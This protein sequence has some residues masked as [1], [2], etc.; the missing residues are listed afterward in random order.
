MAE[1]YAAR[2]LASRRQVAIKLLDP[3]LVGDPGLI[4]RFRHEFLILTRVA[5]PHL[6]RAVDMAMTADAQPYFTMELIRGESLEERLRRVGRIGARAAIE[7]GLQ[8]CGA[9]AA[10][11]R[12]GVIH[13]DVKPSNILLAPC[14]AGLDSRLIDLGIAWLSPT[15]YAD[16]DPYMTPPEARVDTGRGLLLGTP[17][18]TPP[19]AGY[20]RCGPTH[21]VFALGVLLYRAVTG[22]MPF[23]APY[24]ACDGQAPRTFAELGLGTQLDDPPSAALEEVLLAALAL[25][26]EERLRDADELAELLLCAREELDPS[27][28]DRHGERA[29]DRAPDRD[30]DP[31]PDPDLGH[32]PHPDPGHGH[33]SDHGH[34]RHRHRHRHRDRPPRPGTQ[35]PARPEPRERRRPPHGSERPLQAPPRWP[36][37]QGGVA[38]QGEAERPAPADAPQ[39]EP[40]GRGHP[41][42]KADERS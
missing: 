26:P 27:E 4:A 38:A 23:A 39:A 37:G 21:D 2:F 30:D 5:H 7:L 41:R 33:D 40:N 8:L 9:I 3:H 14:T 28:A 35:A 31:H 18:Y 19:E 12:A 34:D 29:P 6:I 42:S 16:T 25:R 10:L 22:R 11:H 13:R 32:D 1:V 15:Y 17:G 36:D 24:G 20:R